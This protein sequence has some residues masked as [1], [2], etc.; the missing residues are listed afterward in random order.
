[1]REKKMG[2]Y[3]ADT[4]DI[5]VNDKNGTFIDHG[6]VPSL[7]GWAKEK[8]KE[9]A[10][11]LK[12][13][14]GAYVWRKLGKNREHNIVHEYQRDRIDNVYVRA[15]EQSHAIHGAGNLSKLEKKLADYGVKMNL[16]RYENFD[17]CSTNAQEFIANLGALYALDRQGYDIEAY[18]QTRDAPQMREAYQAYTAA[19]F[20]EQTG[21]KD[22]PYAPSFGDLAQAYCR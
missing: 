5:L 1:M 3:Y 9:S 18:V 21:R 17:T 8:F 2:M 22:A 13:A 19:K 11:S 12:N 6:A 15:H 10:D 16:S 4:L 7:Y 14:I 20:K